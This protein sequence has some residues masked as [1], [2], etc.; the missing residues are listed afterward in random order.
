MTSYFS[1]ASNIYI[2]CA[3]AREHDLLSY[4]WIIQRTCIVIAG[5]DPGLCKK[6]GPSVESG[7]KLADTA[8][9]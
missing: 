5:P 8:P 9:K 1:L 7:E 6:I 4:E 2:P 3:T